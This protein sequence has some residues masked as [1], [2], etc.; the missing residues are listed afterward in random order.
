M[1]PLETPIISFKIENNHT[2]NAV[3]L[4]HCL[5]EHFFKALKADFPE[6]EN[7]INA[8]F[9]L[10]YPKGEIEI[11]SIE[12]TIIPD[13]TPIR[14][15]TPYHYKTNFVDLDLDFEEFYVRPN[16]SAYTE[17]YWVEADNIRAVMYLLES[18]KNWIFIMAE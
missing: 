17:Y 8:C 10:S 11:V 5:T 18:E 14:I 2:E 12:K 9:E 6:K 4:N 15:L 7:F 16:L 3:F 13:K 1:F